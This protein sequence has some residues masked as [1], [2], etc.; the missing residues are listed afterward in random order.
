ML[1]EVRELVLEHLRE[2]NYETS[3]LTGDVLLGPG[4]LDMDSLGVAELAVRIED[5]YG[6]R[7]GNDA[8]DTFA[9]VTLDEFVAAVVE[10]LDGNAVMPADSASSTDRG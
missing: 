4:G 7:F 9:E 5:T 2:L 3:D 6:V 10:R 8:I 1:A